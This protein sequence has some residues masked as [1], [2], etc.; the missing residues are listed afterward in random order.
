MHLAIELGHVIAGERARLEGVVEQPLHVVELPVVAEQAVDAE[1][2]VDLVVLFERILHDEVIL[3][4]HPRIG[5]VVRVH[6]EVLAVPLAVH[7][8]GV[9]VLDPAVDPDRRILEAQQILKVLDLGFIRLGFLSG[10][11]GGR[12]AAAERGRPLE[13]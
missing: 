11:G 10:L 7:V 3:V 9:A 12:L 4:A 6:A 2:E 13:R 5:E 1:A 8:A